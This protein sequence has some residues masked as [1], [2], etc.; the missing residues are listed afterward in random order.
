MK[1]HVDGMSASG[2]ILHH[3]HHHHHRHPSPYLVYQ[4]PSARQL[5]WCSFIINQSSPIIILLQ[6]VMVLRHWQLAC[7]MLSTC[8]TEMVLPKLSSWYLSSSPQHHPSASPISIIHQHHQHHVH[9]LQS[10]SPSY[11]SSLL[12]LR[13]RMLRRTVS[14]RLAMVFPMGNPTATIQS[15]SPGY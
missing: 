6:V 3:H 5:R 2:G 15:P 4:S 12:M 9:H 13:S 1:H 8:H 10:T 14:A 11:R 7:M